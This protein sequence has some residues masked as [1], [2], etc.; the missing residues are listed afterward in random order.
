[1]LPF[2][3]P[4]ELHSLTYPFTIDIIVLKKLGRFGVTFPYLLSSEIDKPYQTTQ[5]AF[6]V[7]YPVSS[8]LR[9]HRHPSQHP[10]Q[11]NFHPCYLRGLD[12]NSQGRHPKI[13]QP[14]GLGVM[15]LEARGTE[16]IATVFDSA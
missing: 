13:A 9:L 6:V 11:R 5:Q 4:C 7:S 3:N 16:Q 8:V 12:H 10:Y 2:Q 1:M 15:P 14:P